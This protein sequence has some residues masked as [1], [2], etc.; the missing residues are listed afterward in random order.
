MPKKPKTP[1]NP[2]SKAGPGRQK[3]PREL[4]LDDLLGSLDPDTM[5]RLREALAGTEADHDPDVL[6]LLDELLRR[7]ES[8]GDSD[9][10][11]DE[12]LIDDVVAELVQL[13]AD[14]TGGDP[15]ARELAAAV[16][17]KLDNSLAGD[18]FDAAS[19]VL[20]AKILSDS[21]W[22]VPDR[23][24]TRLVEA[25]D[26]APPAEPSEFDLK[27]ALHQIAEAAGDDAFAAHEALSSVLAAF[28]SDAAA[29]MLGVLAFGREPVLLQTLAGFVMH[30]DPAL[31]SSAVAS[32]KNAASGR[33]VESSLVERLVRIRP[34]L[35][36]DR[37][38]PLDEAIRALRGQALPPRE[39]A[40]PTPLKAYVMAC[41]GMGSAGTLATVKGPGGWGFVAAM[42]RPDGVAEVMGLDSARKGEID[43]TVRGMRDSVATAETDAA[44]IGRFLQLSLGENAASRNPP[45]F[46]LIGLVES[47]GLGPLAPRVLTPGE[48]IEELLEGA[49]PLS[50][51]AM[52]KAHLDA[53]M[54]KSATG[55]FEADEPVERLLRP[56]RGSNARVRALLGGYLRERRAFWSRICA[57]SAFALSLGGK[58]E[59]TQ[60]LNLAFVGREILSGTALE[61]IPL[62]RQIAETTV[63][64]FE[65]RG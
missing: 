29:R 60:A 7:L 65:D 20:L 52:Q 22:T 51:A 3:P 55:W 39:T 49:P 32:L 40:R 47:L 58:Q 59:R 8:P 48:L 1:G 12:E 62:M 2:K 13:G 61:S 4:S 46:R 56:L 38:T 26:A 28:P 44:G 50:A 17:E 23:L 24:K 37:Q 27:S 63:L 11:E 5:A 15:E 14:R 43:A 10:S 45:P 64:A 33:K 57:M 18:R 16:D 53:A 35:T 34:W 36:P 54:A 42:T 31:A 21:K 6:D 19:L 41:D 25:L 30:P 9:I